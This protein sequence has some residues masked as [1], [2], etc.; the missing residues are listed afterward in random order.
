[1]QPSADA[2]STMRSMEDVVEAIALD[3]VL[4]KLLRSRLSPRPDAGRAQPFPAS[5]VRPLLSERERAALDWADVLTFGEP[6]DVL[7]A[8]YTRLRRHFDEDEISELTVAI[9]ALNEWRR[10]ALQLEPH[11]L[12]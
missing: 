11:M 2:V 3:S 4:V 8:E 6:A 10:A 5:H 7:E 1:M 9:V 12:L